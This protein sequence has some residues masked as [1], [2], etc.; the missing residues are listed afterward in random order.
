MKDQD[1][2]ERRFDLI[3]VE[4]NVDVEGEAF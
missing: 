3:D 1:E 2:S 4:G